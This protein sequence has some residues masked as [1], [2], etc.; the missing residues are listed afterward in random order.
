MLVLPSVGVG[1]A[2]GRSQPEHL[3]EKRAGYGADCCQNAIFSLGAVTFEALA[4]QTEAS[5]DY[6][7]R[8][9]RDGASVSS[10]LSERDAR[11]GDYRERD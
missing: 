5:K 11:F 7:N 2:D 6:M 1:G 9:R 4:F 3:S 8:F 10:L